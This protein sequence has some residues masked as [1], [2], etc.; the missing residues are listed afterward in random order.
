MAYFN[1]LLII[2]IGGV[3]SLLEVPGLMQPEKRGELIAFCGFLLIGMVLA[4]AIT[5]KLPLPNPVNGIESVFRPIARLF[6]PQ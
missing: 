5:L 2:L 6:Y 1:L 4:V 3:I